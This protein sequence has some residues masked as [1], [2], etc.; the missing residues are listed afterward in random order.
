MVGHHWKQTQGNRA[1]KKAK[2]RSA[3]IFQGQKVTASSCHEWLLFFLHLQAGK[4]LWPNSNKTYF[5]SF[6]PS[7]NRF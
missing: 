2:L 4:F 1:W 5:L 7:E 3:N 6:L